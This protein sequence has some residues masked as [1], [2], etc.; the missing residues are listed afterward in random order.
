MGKAVM[1]SIRPNWCEK[2]IGGEKTIEV[3]KNRPKLETPFK[4]YIYCTKDAKMQWRKGPRYSPVDDH[5]HNAFD[6]CGNGKVIGEFV[7]DCVTPLYNV[8]TDDWERL[9]GELHLIEKELVNQA[10]LTEAQLHTYAGGKNCF[11]WHIS[12]LK[13]YD[14]PKGF[15]E[16][17]VYNEALHK[18]YEAGTDFCCY[19]AADEYGEAMTDCGDAYTEIFNCYRCWSEWSGWC[20]RVNRP[21]QS[22]FYV[23]EIL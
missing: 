20:H 3:R 4:C 18:R 13:I 21:P 14:T 19:D 6:K 17:W 10:C 16:F 12:H 11:A 23:E 22:W 5:S 2:I 8:C 9:T 1:I 7:C 15:N